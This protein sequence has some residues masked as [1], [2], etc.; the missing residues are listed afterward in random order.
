MGFHHHG[1]ADRQGGEDKA[2]EHHRQPEPGVV[3]KDHSGE[4]GDDDDQHHRKQR[5]RDPGQHFPG[6]V[7]NVADGRRLEFSKMR[8]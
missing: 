8:Q 6:N 5:P 4:K 7:G 1:Q 2:V 3:G